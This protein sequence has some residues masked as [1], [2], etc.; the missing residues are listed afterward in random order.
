MR[1]RDHV[2]TTWSFLFVIA[3]I[4]RIFSPEVLSWHFFVGGLA[5][6]GQVL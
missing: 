6:A 4:L 5:V 1:H 2:V 3:Q